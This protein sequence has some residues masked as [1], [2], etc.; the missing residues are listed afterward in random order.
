M[1][2]AAEQDVEVSQARKVFMGVIHYGLLS[3]AMYASFLHWFALVRHD[4]QGKLE[5]AFIAGCVDLVVY[6]ATLYRQRDTRIGRKPMYGFCTFPNLVLVLAICGSAAGNVAE[7]KHSFGGYS[8]AL[9]PTLTF[10]T[11]L[12][13]GERDLAETDRRNARKRREAIARAEALE[14]D[15]R[16]RAEAERLR[17]EARAEEERLAAEREAKRLE[18]E[19]RRRL[20]DAQRL[21]GTA[22]SRP[23]T[24]SASVSETVSAGIA[25]VVP[26]PEARA[27]STDRIKM[28]GAWVHAIKHERKI[29]NG[30]ELLRAA[31]CSPE[32]S[33]GRRMAANWSRIEPAKSLIAALGREASG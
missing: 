16:R 27:N 28:W 17:Q 25:G 1:T 7:A 32:S 24:V 19:E 10:L 30:A 6:L 31:G 20:A 9:I 29:L 15:T 22:P 4:G 23:G 14:E 8:V 13:L 11:A 12:T 33:L 3:F 5:A 21:A 26:P 18:G 2:A